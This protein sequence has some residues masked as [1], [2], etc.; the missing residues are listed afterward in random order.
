MQQ[1]KHKQSSGG[2]GAENLPPPTIFLSYLNCRSEGK[3]DLTLM[4]FLWFLIYLEEENTYCCMTTISR[5]SYQENWGFSDI[6]QFSNFMPFQVTV[7]VGKGTLKWKFKLIVLYVNTHVALNIF[8]MAYFYV[9]L[10]E[11]QQFQE[12]FPTRLSSCS[13]LHVVSFVSVWITFIKLKWARKAAKI[14]QQGNQQENKSTGKNNFRLSFK[15]TSPQ[16]ALKISSN[17]FK[18]VIKNIINKKVCLWQ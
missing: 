4:L 2:Q 3:V 8:P 6:K 12:R 5:M 14:N 17:V 16:R 1:N 15:Q 9:T 18:Q 7:S 10:K 11:K 13:Q